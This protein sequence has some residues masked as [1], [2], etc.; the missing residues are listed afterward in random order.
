MH[1][2]VALHRIAKSTDFQQLRHSAPLRE[3]LAQLAKSAAQAVGMPGDPRES[4]ILKGKTMGKPWEHG[5]LPSGKQPH[6]YG[7]SPSLRGKS[8]INGT[9][10]IAMSN[11][12]RVPRTWGFYS[13]IF[14]L[15]GKYCDIADINWMNQRYVVVLPRSMGISTSHAGN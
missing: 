10:S 15:A 11:Y 7:K 3:Q 1:L 2:V 14:F 9:C 13:N 12:Q 6:R 4:T 5:A 8:T